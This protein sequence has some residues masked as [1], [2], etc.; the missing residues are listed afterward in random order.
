VQVQG[1]VV[2][3]ANETFSVNLSG[4]TNAT[5]ADDSGL[6]TIT[7]NDTPTITLGAAVAVTE[8]TG[9]T[10]NAVFGLTL[11]AP[12]GNTVTVDFATA[13]GSATDPSDYLGTSGT[14]TF[15]PGEVSKQIVVQV[16]GDIAIEPNETFSLNLSNPA[17]AT[18]AGTGF[19]LGTITDNDTPT[20]TIASVTVTEGNAGTL[21]AVFN[22]T[23]SAPSGNTVTV[24]F[25]TANGSAIASGDYTSLSGLVTFNPGVTGRQIIVQVVGDVL[26]EPNETFSVNLS[27][28]INATIAGSGFG[29]GTITNND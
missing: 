20:I 13:D 2:S 9:G 22:V 15:N 28:P 23:L 16:V 7:D 11:S 24:N 21:S 1:D 19:A 8:G 5:I 12:N 10:T 18:I 4:A 3:E 17:N 26:I 14:A 29:V 27:N 6:G 25:A